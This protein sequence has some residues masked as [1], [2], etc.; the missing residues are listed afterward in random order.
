M[1]SSE[2]ETRLR[3]RELLM[4]IGIVLLAAVLR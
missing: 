2:L 1:E 4:A 3:G